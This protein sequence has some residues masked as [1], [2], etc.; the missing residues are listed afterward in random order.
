MQKSNI[1]HSDATILK[2]YELYSD[3]QEL[4]RITKEKY[5]EVA[6]MVARAYY[7]NILCKKHNLTPNYICSI[8]CGIMADEEN[9]KREVQRA[10]FNLM[11]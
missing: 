10:S 2:H 8:I 7:Y 4:C 1:R 6:D 11:D 3:Y 9:F 5:P